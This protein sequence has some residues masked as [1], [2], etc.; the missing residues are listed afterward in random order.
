[1]NM[2]STFQTDRGIS[3]W[4]NGFGEEEIEGKGKRAFSPF[5]LFPLPQ[6][7]FP[8]YKSGRIKPDSA[9]RQLCIH[10]DIEPEMRR[11]E[12]EEQTNGHGGEEDPEGTMPDLE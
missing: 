10:V 7:Y 4:G 5:S 12:T 9:C 11:A 3:F 6:T 2:I 8:M 1:M